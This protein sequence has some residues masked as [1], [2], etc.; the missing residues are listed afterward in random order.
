MS[1]EFN[2]QD[3][4]SDSRATIGPSISIR[5]EVTGSED[6]LIEGNIEGA[7]DLK[8]NTVTVGKGAKVNA[9]ITGNIIH[10][11]GHVTGDLY[12]A[13]QV[14]VHGTGCVRGNIASPRLILE[15]G[16]RLKGSIDTEPGS[17]SAMNVE[18][19][20]TAAADETAQYGRMNGD[21]KRNG[22]HSVRSN[23]AL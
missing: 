6:L 3:G 17:A 21:A 13:E 10:V 16:A 22:S 19:T 8:D 5:G 14:V 7:V 2:N 23:N 18:K 12:G 20:R 15:D 1:K 9:S 11:E 4:S